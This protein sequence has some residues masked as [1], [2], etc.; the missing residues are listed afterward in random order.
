MMTAPVSGTVCTSEITTS[1]VPGR[2]IDQKK[3]EFA[4]LHLL[5]E[6]ANDLVQ[7]GT[8]HH[9]WLIAGRDKAHR[10]KFD[11]MGDQRLDLVVL[12]HA[13]LL[14]DAHHERNVGSVDVSV[15]EA[16]AKA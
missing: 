7:H 15:D 5:Q 6:L 10:D 3:I 8:A 12:E 13:R 16:N 14:A 4:P 2:K 11:A 9:Q 1:P